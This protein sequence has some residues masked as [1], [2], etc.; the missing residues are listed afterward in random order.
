MQVES[1]VVRAEV[2]PA[3]CCGYSLCVDVC[4]EVF[5]LDDGGF[6]VAGPVSVGLEAKAREAADACP[7]S[8]ITVEENVAPRR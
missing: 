6:A 5:R 8:A 4:P 3:K 2:D 1:S 7:E